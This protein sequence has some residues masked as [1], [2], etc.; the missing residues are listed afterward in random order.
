LIRPQSSL[1]YEFVLG[2]FRKPRWHVS[3]LRDFGDLPGA[4]LCLFERQQIE[5]RRLSRPMTRS[6]VLKENRSDVLGERDWTR[7]YLLLPWP[8]NASLP[9]SI[10]RKDDESS[11]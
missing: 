3:A 9:S 2:G 8:Y 7:D 10:H 1:P 5:R 6:A 4:F 11:Q